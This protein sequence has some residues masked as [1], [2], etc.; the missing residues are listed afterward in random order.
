M[1]LMICNRIGLAFV[2]QTNLSFPIRLSGTTSSNCSSQENVETIKFNVRSLIEKKFGPTCIPSPCGG[3]GWTRV[4]Y[5][6]MSEPQ[7]TCPSNWNLTTSPVRGCGRSSTGAQMC[8]SVVYP[9]NGLTYNNVCGRITAYHKGW[10]EGFSNRFTP[11]SLE[12][13]HVSG[14]SLTHGLPGARQ[15][16]WTFVGAENDERNA[17]D[18][19]PCA[20]TNTAWPHQIPSF[21]G[22]D[23]F[24]DTGRHEKGIDNNAF[25]FNDPLWD[26]EG[27]G[28]T[29]S[30]CEFN[31]PPWFCKSLPQPTTDDLEIRLCGYFPKSFED[32]IISLIDIFVN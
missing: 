13:A 29:S 21:I 4:A 16:V 28:S 8:D 17:S 31:S 15:H 9:I 20:N 19:C 10:S 11:S 25:Y 32:K 3:A 1:Q 24:C 2:M 18:N 12:V 23:Y 22:N 27:C 6:N 7:Q 5:L 26:G 30:C 14:V